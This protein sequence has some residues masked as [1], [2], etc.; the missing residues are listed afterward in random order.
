MVTHQL[1]V[2]CRPGKVRRSTFYHTELYGHTTTAV[3]TYGAETHRYPTKLSRSSSRNWTIDCVIWW[4]T[5]HGCHQFP[6]KLSPSVLSELEWQANI[7]TQAA[8]MNC[9]ST[10]IISLHSVSICMTCNSLSGSGAG[11]GA[12]RSKFPLTAQTSFSNPA[13]VTSRLPLPLHR[14]FSSLAPAHPIFGP[15]PLHFSLPLPLRS[16]SLLSDQLKAES[17]IL[18]CRFFFV[19][20]LVFKK[21]FNNYYL[22]ATNLKHYIQHTSVT[23]YL[24]S[25]TGISLKTHFGFYSFIYYRYFILIFLL[26][27]FLMVI[28]LR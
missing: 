1:Q 5:Q 6:R 3:E 10:G 25:L 12:E 17:A 13:H 4:C 7:D 21:S 11:A 2:W 28:F 23:K 15:A 27:C 22:F 24:P 8:R 16:H 19:T 20:I 26:F 14:I 18:V 9:S